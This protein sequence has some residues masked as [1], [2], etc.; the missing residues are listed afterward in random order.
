MDSLQFIHKCFDRLNSGIPLGDGLYWGGNFE[1]LKLLIQR[2]EIK[3]DEIKF[4]L[5]YS[6]WT[7]KQLQDELKENTWIISHDF[8]PD[9]VFVQAEE[10]LW[11]E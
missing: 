4:F 11:K 5:G 3:N 9:L 7:E 1:V 6:G 2:G 8:N 10:N